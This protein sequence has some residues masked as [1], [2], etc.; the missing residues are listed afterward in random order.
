MH[1]VPPPPPP[2]NRVHHDNPCLSLQ[3]LAELGGQEKGIWNIGKS[4]A[5]FFQM[6]RG[7]TPPGRA[8][9]VVFICNSSPHAEDKRGRRGLQGSERRIRRQKKPLHL[10]PSC[11]LLSPPPEQYKTQLTHRLPRDAGQPGESKQYP[12]VPHDY[13]RGSEQQSKDRHAAPKDATKLQNQ[14]HR[15]ADPTPLSPLRAQAMASRAPPCPAASSCARRR[16]RRSSLVGSLQAHQLQ[17]GVG[18]LACGEQRGGRGAVHG[19]LLLLPP[20]LV[21]LCRP[22]ARSALAPS[23]PVPR[24][25]SGEVASPARWLRRQPSSEAGREGGESGK[26]WAAGRERGSGV[27]PEGSAQ[28]RRSRAGRCPALLF[29]SARLSRAVACEKQAAARLLVK[30]RRNSC[31]ITAQIGRPSSQWGGGGRGGFAAAAPA[32]CFANPS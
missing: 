3:T 28:P 12:H 17:G 20:P 2:M 23:K 27:V 11:S 30:A 9:V 24:P 32:P 15:L 10:H 21:L 25:P 8:G 22:R 6:S 31:R 16:R 5:K 13:S 1:P 4:K 18:W 26:V 29:C 14:I 19:L 7:V